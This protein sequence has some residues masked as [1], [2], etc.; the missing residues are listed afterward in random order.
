MRPLASLVLA[1]A[2]WENHL[3]YDEAWRLAI[4]EE[5][6]QAEAWGEDEEA[7][8]YRRAK[9]GDVLAAAQFMMLVKVF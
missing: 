2:V 7:Q 4:L 9:Y 1:L 6:F 3:S 5:S 8:Q